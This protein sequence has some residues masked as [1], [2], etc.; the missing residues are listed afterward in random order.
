MMKLLQKGCQNEYIL[1]IDLGTTN[2]KFAL[3][4]RSLRL[5]AVHTKPVDYI[6]Q[7]SFVEFDPEQYFTCFVEGILTLLSDFEKE[8][9]GVVLITLT[10][11]AESIVLTDTQSCPVCSG[12][13]WKDSRSINETKS[14]AEFAGDDWF[15]ITGLPQVTTTWPVT[16][17]LWMRNH[18]PELF[19]RIE[20]VYLL[21]DYI[22]YRLTGEFVSEY[23]IHSFSGWMRSRDKTFWTE[24]L[25]YLGIRRSMLPRMI[26]T[27]SIVGSLTSCSSSALHLGA[28]VQVSIGALDHVAGMVGTGNIEAGKITA[29]LGTV[30]ALAM[31]AECILEKNYGIEYHPGFSPKSIIQLM[32]IESG[33]ISMQWFRD[34]F[35]PATSFREID[36]R[37]S[38]DE[39]T[40]SD[41]LYLPYVCGVNPPE[42]DP[43]VTG[44]FHGFDISCNIW[45]FTRAVM[46][47][48]GFLLRKNLDFLEKNIQKITEIFA[49]GGAANS[50]IFCQFLADITQ[51]RLVTF[52]STESVALGAA[53]L[54]AVAIGF[55]DS[56]EQAVAQ[57]VTQSS[58]F[59]PR[60][61][62]YYDKKYASFKTLYDKIFGR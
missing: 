43:K 49:I 38:E 50:S 31:N 51:K 16:K 27:G 41:L 13:S 58:V 7:G 26:E 39:S 55:F 53:I 20:R 4:D 14:I 54:G 23:S 22:A 57:C 2:F 3:Y 8:S 34:S 35:M 6:E 15:R 52:D 33:G 21:K 32:V 17:L 5:I 36:L 59:F 19:K 60:Q 45:H 44:V 12:I 11:Q 28:S 48:N 24:M 1:S 25:E 47:A 37:L 18:Q 29:S 9:S 62:L 56:M 61:I 42:N 10:G 30:N 40:K 46:E